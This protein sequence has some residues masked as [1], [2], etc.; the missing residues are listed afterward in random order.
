MKQCLNL[1][2]IMVAVIILLCG[3]GLWLSWTLIQLVR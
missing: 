1:G 3:L 2:T